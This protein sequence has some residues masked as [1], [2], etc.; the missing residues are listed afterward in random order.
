MGKRNVPKLR[1]KG[2]NDKWKECS[3]KELCVINPKTAQLPDKFNYIDLES[4]VS[5]TLIKNNLMELKNAPSRAQ[6]LLNKGDVLFQTVRPYQMNNFLFDIEIGCENVASTGYAQLRVKNSSYNKFI[7]QLIHNKGFNNKVMLRCTGTSYPAINSSELA[8]IPIK[9]PS[10]EEQ[11]KIA[12]FLS[13]VDKIIEE[14]EGKVK[15]LE[16]YKKG[17]MQKIFKQEIRFKD[18]NGQDYPEWEETLLGDIS[19]VRDGT[20][21]SPKYVEEGYPL[22][23]SKNLMKNGSIDYSNVNYITESDYIN[24]N[25]RSE[26]EI[27][28]IL[29]GMI[30]TI[31]NPV[32][33]DKKGFAIKNVAL[34]KEK[35]E[36]KNIYL[37][38]YL[39]SSLIGEQF[40]KVNTGGTQKFI[41]LNL[42]RNL[43]IQLPC[44]EEQEKIANFL[45][46]I[47]KII[48]EENKKLEDLR[49][50]KK[51][52][53]Q[54][55][56]V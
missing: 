45:S 13:N 21:E 52:L 4:I 10:L 6:R 54:Q 48:E 40:Y 12:N 1:F 41:A 47:D 2:F 7:Y 37:L 43:K 29:F 9:V 18:D 14:Q 19:D 56:F 24:I 36:L 28:D 46:N 32:L 8:T 53:L 33:V 23:T 30:G 39:N 22:I 17:M 55:M 34:I 31:G 38:V 44:L 3:L 20:H 27:G 50:W 11:T 5:G 26:V 15:D 25:K 16:L 35:N 51:G 49:Q 42:I